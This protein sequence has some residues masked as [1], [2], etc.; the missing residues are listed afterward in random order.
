MISFITLLGDWKQL[1]QDEASSEQPLLWAWPSLI[2]LGVV[3]SQ[4]V[5]LSKFFTLTG[6]TRLVVTAC[7]TDNDSSV[8]LADWRREDLSTLARLSANNLLH[9]PR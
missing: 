7:G 1:Q 6:A 8:P 4:T 9:A 2:D 5:F 3:R